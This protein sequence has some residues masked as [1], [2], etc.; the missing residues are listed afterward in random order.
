MPSLAATGGGRRRGGGRGGS[1]TAKPEPGQRVAV[2]QKVH[3]ESGERT[4]GVVMDVLTRSSQHSRGFKVRLTSGIVGRTVEILSEAPQQATGGE[5]S[6]PSTAMAAGDAP[7]TPS[8]ADL[9]A[10]PLDDVVGL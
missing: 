7:A 8:A 4:V 10:M 6:E 3:Y 1:P 9:L 5:A 2:L